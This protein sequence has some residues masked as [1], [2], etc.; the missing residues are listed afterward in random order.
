MNDDDLM[1]AAARAAGEPVADGPMDPEL[2][3]AMQVLRAATVPADASR[4]A[5]FVKPAPVIKL[6]Y[7]AVAAV[8]FF[9]IGLVTLFKVSFTPPQHIEPVAVVNVPPAQQQSGSPDTTSG[10]T[11]PEPPVVHTRPP[12]VIS[13]VERVQKISA[14]EYS[15]GGGGRVGGTPPGGGGKAGSGGSDAPKP[16]TP[17]ERLSRLASESSGRLFRLK[18]RQ[19]MLDLKEVS[20]VVPPESRDL[21]IISTT[22]AS[23]HKSTVLVLQ[24]PD[25]PAARAALNAD[26]L[27]GNV[28]FVELDGTL[29]LLVSNVL[30]PDTL[31][32]L[33]LEAVPAK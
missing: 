3:H 32:K 11:E 21:T 28:Y 20:E 18:G 12:W 7:F 30:T 19:H 9:C 8:V 15:G 14:V 23:Y 6:H 25:S 31:S 1:K 24:A 29:L 26:E 2:E 22:Y 33:A 4:R 13:E 10:D 16:E 27:T 5:P 17:A